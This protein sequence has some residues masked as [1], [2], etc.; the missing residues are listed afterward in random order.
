MYPAESCWG[1]GTLERGGVL[2]QQRA[3]TEF[4]EQVTYGHSWSDF[5]QSSRLPYAAEEW[6]RGGRVG[7]GE[8]LHSRCRANSGH[9][10]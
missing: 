3:R 4:W 10:N 9:M 2:A 8:A 5:T 7:R 1:L 6:V